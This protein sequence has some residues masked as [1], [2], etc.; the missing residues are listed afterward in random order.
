MFSSLVTINNQCSDLFI[1]R[2]SYFLGNSIV[3]D[4]S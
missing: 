1:L 3:V 2:E 4:Y